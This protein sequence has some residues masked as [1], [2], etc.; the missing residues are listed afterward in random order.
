MNNKSHILL[1]DDEPEILDILRMMLKTDGFEVSTADCGEAA[2]KKLGEASYDA[3]VCD[4]MMPRMD[5]ITLLKEVRKN[6]N[7]TPFVFFSG[8]AEYTHAV[9]MKSLGAYEFIQK[10][11]VE[12][13]ADVLTKTIKH[14]ETIKIL[15]PG[16]DDDDDGFMDLLFTSNG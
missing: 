15:N 4:Y 3:V 7:Y 16:L 8:N 6:K 10:P 2:L 14:N 13:L 1:I 11:H 5:G 12:L 9:K